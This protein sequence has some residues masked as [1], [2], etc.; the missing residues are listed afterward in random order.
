MANF[1]AFK[2]CNFLLKE[3]QVCK[4][5][6]HKHNIA[7][8]PIPNAPQSQFSESIVTTLNLAHKAMQDN[9]D[10]YTTKAQSHKFVPLQSKR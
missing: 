3:Q 9:R 2:K 7:L 1:K 10:S 4:R 6:L 8:N 5:T